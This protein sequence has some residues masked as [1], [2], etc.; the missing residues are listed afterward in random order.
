MCSPLDIGANNTMEKVVVE[1]G[2]NPHILV[3]HVLGS[4]RVKGWDSGE[5]RVDAE[6]DDTLKLD[7]LKGQVKIRCESGCVLRIPEGSTLE[8]R[9]VEGEFSL[10][11]VEGEVSI[12][13]VL[14]Q[15]ILKNCGP[16]KIK[17][18]EGALTAKQVEGDLTAESVIGP[19]MVQ[20]V[21]GAL[22]LPSVEGNLTLKG[23]VLS[24]KAKV[25][26]NAFLRFEP[27]PGASYQLQSEGYVDCRVPS[28]VSAKVTLM[29]EGGT[30]RVR[31]AGDKQTVRAERHEF[32]LGDGNGTIELKAIGRVDFDAASDQRD[33]DLEFDIDADWVPEVAG[34]AEEITQQVTEQ[35][36][37]QIESLTEQLAGFSSQFEEIGPRGEE[38]VRRAE[39]KLA[40]TQRNL[41]RKLAA[42]Q[43]RAERKTQEAARHARH[44]AHRSHREGRR[45]VNV[46]GTPQAKNDPVSDAERMMILQMVQDKKIGVQEAETLLAALEG[47]GSQPPAPPSPPEPPLPPTPPTAPQPPNSDGDEE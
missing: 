2:R 13:S 39:R 15:V 20:D 3:E 17:Q 9:Q 43:R 22:V 44:T 41:Q 6:H 31:A 23:S 27:E 11:S 30:I 37:A 1:V 45:S 32:T 7:H 42:A 12:G 10:K 38:A 33:P 29:S 34:L 40:A 8:V 19:A 21:E 18:I 25:L 46:F 28:R 14:G 16:V 4:L 26:G 35:I 24:L 36:E 47:Q 5:I